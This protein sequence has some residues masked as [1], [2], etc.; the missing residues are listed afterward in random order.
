[1]KNKNEVNL[2]KRVL[3]LMI[4]MQKQKVVFWFPI[5]VLGFPVDQPFYLHFILFQ[6]EKTPDLDN[7]IHLVLNSSYLLFQPNSTK[8]SY[9]FRN[10]YIYTVL[11]KGRKSNLCTKTIDFH[12]SPIW[13][14]L[15]INHF[16][17][18]YTIHINC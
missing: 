1:M 11:K 4:S 5:L 7:N 8:S 12:T 16:V 9:W 17:S 3:L 18:L 13:K 15:W 6:N 14:V 2:L 10:K